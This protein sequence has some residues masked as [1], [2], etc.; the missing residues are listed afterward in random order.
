MTMTMTMMTVTMEGMRVKAEAFA[1]NSQTDYDGDFDQNNEC[2]GDRVDDKEKYDGIQGGGYE[3]EGRSLQELRRR[4][5]C[6]NG[7]R[8][9]ATPGGRGD[10]HNDDDLD[11][12]DH[13]YDDHDDD[14]DDHD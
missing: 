10:Q 1:D 14:L 2:V 6:V 4:C 9:L 7:P 13:D 8:S 12:Y 3:G 5:S 11:D